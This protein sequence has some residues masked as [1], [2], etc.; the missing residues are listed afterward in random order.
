MYFSI[1]LLDGVPAIAEILT[2]EKLILK[3][4]LDLILFKIPAFNL[5]IVTSR[6]HVCMPAANSKSC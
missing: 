3:W 2:Q 4:K 6:E 5:F 1:L